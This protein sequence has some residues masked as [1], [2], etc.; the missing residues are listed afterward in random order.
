MSFFSLTGLL[1]S[2]C[3]S[4]GTLFFMSKSIYA[5]S[6]L[7]AHFWILLLFIV[8]FFHLI[9][10]VLYT[11]HSF[12]VGTASTA[13]DCIY[14]YCKAVD[15]ICSVVRIYEL[16]FLFSSPDSSAQLTQRST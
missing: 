1:F 5:S 4:C 8:S 6:L 15:F 7:L 11:M 10:E 13:S 12:K 14:L 2:L 16:F 9:T 3:V